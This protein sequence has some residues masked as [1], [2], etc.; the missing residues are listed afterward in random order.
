L[1]EDD[2]W[3]IEQAY[4]LAT[5]RTKMFGFKWEVDHILPVAR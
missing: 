2:Y 5:L 4:E 3:M 1:T